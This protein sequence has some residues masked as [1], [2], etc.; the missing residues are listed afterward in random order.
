MVRS[1]WHLPVSRSCPESYQERG[2]K[3]MKAMREER[4]TRRLRFNADDDGS[5]RVKA[6][7]NGPVDR[8]TIQL[9]VYNKNNRRGTTI[10]SNYE[11]RVLPFKCYLRCLDHPDSSL[12]SFPDRA[13]QLRLQ[14]HENCLSFF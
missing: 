14:C 9:Q 8:C 7:D 4:E 5:G 1:E 11:P 2:F 3:R 13:N 12:Q 10:N 6:T